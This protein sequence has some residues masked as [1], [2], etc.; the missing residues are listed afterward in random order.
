[1][2]R[3]DRKNEL[4]KLAHNQ[5]L[6]H[7]IYYFINKQFKREITRHPPKNINERHFNNKPEDNPRV[8]MI[9]EPVDWEE[10]K[11]NLRSHLY[12]QPLY[13]VGVF[14]DD[15]RV[16]YH[17]NQIRSYNNPNPIFI[18]VDKMM[19]KTWSQI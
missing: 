3:E 7:E 8:L 17:F 13:Y 2:I 16:K 9:N 19:T 1:M 10:S 4:R 14:E 5:R 6:K 18:N 12:T 11:N 15:F